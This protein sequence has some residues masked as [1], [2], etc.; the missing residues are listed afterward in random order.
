MGNLR[1]QQREASNKRILTA[2]INEFSA[3]GY[4]GTLLSRIAKEASVSNSIIT[5]RI[6]GK[7]NLFILVFKEMIR[8]FH[9]CMNLQTDLYT[10]LISLVQEVK[11]QAAERTSNYS[12]IKMLLTSRDIPESCIEYQKKHFNKS[13]IKTKLTEAMKNGTIIKGDEWKIFRTFMEVIFSITDVYISSDLPVLSDEQYLELLHY[14]KSAADNKTDSTTHYLSPD[15]TAN[16]NSFINE[17][18]DAVMTELSSEFDYVCYLDTNTQRTSIFQISNEFQKIMDTIDPILSPIE[19]FDEFFNKIV[20]PEDYEGF[21]EDV[22]HQKIENALLEAQSYE[23]YFRIKLNQKLFYYRLK[24]TRDINNPDGII[25]CLVS[26]DDEIRAEMR[27]SEDE[28]ARLAMERNMQI[29]ITERT[30]EIQEKNKALNRINED[31]IELLGDITEARDIE[32][33]EHIRRVKGFTHILAEQVMLDWPEYGLTQER[34]ELMTSASALHDIGKIMI[35]DAILLKPGKLLSDEFDIMK[36]HCV[37]GCE[38]LKKAPQDWSADYLN[39]SM[40]ICRWHHEKYDGKGYPDGLKGEEIP[41][42]AQIVSV[43]DCFDALSSKRIYKDAFEPDRAYNMIMNGECGCFSEKILSSFTRCKEKFVNHVANRHDSYL[44]EYSNSV[45]TRSLNGIRILLAEDEELN[46][47]IVVFMLKSEGAIVTAVSN[48]IE[49][50]ETLRSAGVGAYDVVLMD[51]Q[52]PQMNGID[53]TKKIRTLNSAYTDTIPIIALTAS[54]REEDIKECLNAGMN[55]YLTK[56]VNIK[57][58]STVMIECMKNKVA[59]LHE[60]MIAQIQRTNSDLLTGVR[61]IAAY[62][63]MII[64]LSAQMNSGERTEFAVIECDLNNLKFINDT[65]GH[66]FGDIYINNCCNILIDVFRKQPIYRID[67]DEFIII[68]KDDGYINREILF[69][70]LKERVRKAETIVDLSHGKTSFAIGFVEYNPETDTSVGEL[71]KRAKQSMYSNKRLVK[72]EGKYLES[73]L[74][75]G[76]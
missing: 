32:S 29:T 41:I 65:Y 7:E 59:K 43:A 42:S 1:D 71:I 70:K 3:M 13:E 54:S 19:R 57:S 47:E 9:V 50:V 66:D 33:G 6:G 18:H 14:K 16:N 58:L 60:Q 46:C 11:K 45:K 67:G 20:A 26:S 38:I 24:I 44:P 72:F 21:R 12:Y 25:L 55:S 30:A 5:E 2:A 73:F 74:T 75:E 63:D 37:K 28:N 17:Y 56:P 40:E 15:G 23:V 27:R 49:A 51:I 61:N 39:T 64:E 48:G 22:I 4:S 35:P 52:M 31:I 53:A 68:L 36:T 62:T 8:P 34:V 76:K 69:N 10:I